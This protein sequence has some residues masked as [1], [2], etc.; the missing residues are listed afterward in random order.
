M[1]AIKLRFSFALAIACVLSMAGFAQQS[2]DAVQTADASCPGT[3][4][5]TVRVESGGGS[6]SSDFDVKWESL[7]PGMFK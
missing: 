2:N 3:S 6:G 7:V 5:L 4:E 1:N